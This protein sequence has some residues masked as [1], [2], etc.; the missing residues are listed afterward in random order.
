M[1]KRASIKLT[2]LENVIKYLLN[3]PYHEVAKL[4]QSLEQVGVCDCKEDKVC[5]CENPEKD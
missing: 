3:R 2:D 5:K 4:M 1:E